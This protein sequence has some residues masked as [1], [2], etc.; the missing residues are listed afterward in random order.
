MSGDIRHHIVINNLTIRYMYSVIFDFDNTLT[1]CDVSSQI[2]NLIGNEIVFTEMVLHNDFKQLLQILKNKNIKLFVLSFGYNNI[3]INYLKNHDLYKYFDGIYTP[4]SFG[5]KDG[6]SYAKA[7]N[8]KNKLI[9]IICKGIL[10][11][12]I[13]LVDDNRTNIAWAKEEGFKV[14]MIDSR[15][16]ITNDDFVNL[17][18]LTKY[19]IKKN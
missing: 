10:N 16:G 8:G 15:F 12:N 14:L 3:I 11:E 19:W 7:A 2:D 17:C 1:K 13:L 5:L 18:G 6:Y 9:K 4:S